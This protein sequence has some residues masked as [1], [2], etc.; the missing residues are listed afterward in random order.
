MIGAMVNRGR[1]GF[2]ER[3]TKR[4]QEN[5]ERAG[6]SAAASYSLIGAILMLGGIGYLVDRWC[7]TSH[8]FLLAG[9]VLGLIVGF[10]QLART[11]WR[12]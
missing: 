11:V 12:K 7:G 8:W 5:A 9:L 3:S 2:L 4:F 10:Y 1:R 6:P